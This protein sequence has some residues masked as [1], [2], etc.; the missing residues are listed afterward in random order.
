MRKLGRRK[1]KGEEGKK[2]PKHL[3]VVLA[4]SHTA[5]LGSLY[6][7]RR[8]R[9]SI[10]PPV[11]IDHQRSGMPLQSPLVIPLSRAPQV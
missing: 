7:P 2:A 6:T 1:E 3:C 5:T 8:P 10:L 4:P 9:L 11:Q